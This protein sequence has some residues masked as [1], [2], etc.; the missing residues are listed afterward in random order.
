[1]KIKMSDLILNYNMDNRGRQKITLILTHFDI[2][3]NSLVELNEELVP[4][5]PEC[6]SHIISNPE[7]LV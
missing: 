2:Y 1:M 3:D 5:I 6:Y 7:F 4:Q